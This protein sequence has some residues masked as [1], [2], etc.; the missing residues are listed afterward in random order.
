LL[1]DLDELK[2]LE[3]KKFV[4]GYTVLLDPVKL[5]YSMTALIL[6]Q[7]EGAHITDAEYKESIAF[8][9]GQQAW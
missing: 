7:T 1:K 3:E 8:L 5:G 6:I 9:K 2:N 4:K